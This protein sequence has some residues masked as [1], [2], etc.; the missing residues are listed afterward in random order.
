MHKNRPDIGIDNLWVDLESTDQSEGDT[1]DTEG[2]SG[3]AA[4]GLARQSD[5]PILLLTGVLSTA[6][7]ALLGS[8]P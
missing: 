5:F 1:L 4:R 6:A 3:P 8:Y 2:V 7:I